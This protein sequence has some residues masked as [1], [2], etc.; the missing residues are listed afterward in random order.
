MFPGPA[1]RP[2]PRRS[3]RAAEAS[4]GRQWR[5]PRRGAQPSPDGRRG[6]RP[7]SPPDL[8]LTSRPDRSAA[9]A[10]THLPEAPASSG[11]GSP[12][13]SASNSRGFRSRDSR[14]R[15]LPD[16][17]RV[18]LRR[19]GFRRRPGLA[20]PRT[21]TGLR[22]ALPASGLIFHL[23]GGIWGMRRAPNFGVWGKR[24]WCCLRKEGSFPERERNNFERI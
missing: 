13:F 20:G 22:E 14:V 21:A 15:A 18:P 7:A 5:P 16:S 12:K 10:S 1:P 11:A 8:Q 2:R 17:G 6:P 19:L 4:A 9:A 24:W 3:A 23:S